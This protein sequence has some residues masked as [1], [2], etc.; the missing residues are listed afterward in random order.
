M[1]DPQ[2]TAQDN[3]TRVFFKSPC[4]PAFQVVSLW[5]F[6]Q[7]EASAALLSFAIKSSSCCSFCHWFL[8]SGGTQS[9]SFCSQITK[10]NKCFS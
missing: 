3:K 5:P 8:L 6:A 1:A 7:Q 10:H 9:F 2:E 4:P